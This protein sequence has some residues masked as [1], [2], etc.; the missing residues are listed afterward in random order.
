MLWFAFNALSYALGR[1]FGL[2]GLAKTILGAAC[3]VALVSVLLDSDYVARFFERFMADEGSADTR[4]RM[5]GLFEAMSWHDL[6][7]GPDARVLGSLQSR[8]GITTAIESFIL[9]YIFQSGL[10][11]AFTV[12]GALVI[13]ACQIARRLPWQASLGLVFFFAVNATSTG[14]ASKTVILSQAVAIL[15]LLAPPRGTRPQPYRG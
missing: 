6:I 5:F 7:F 1:R 12:F 15:C 4:L 3:L 14:I 2:L 11:A 8:F 13:L 9:S 10:F